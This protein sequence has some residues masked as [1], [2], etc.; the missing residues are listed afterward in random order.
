M[1]LWTFFSNDLN[2][3]HVLLPVMAEGLHVHI[4]CAGVGTCR[5][6]K[7]R[8]GGCTGSDPSMSPC[9]G[10]A[11]LTYLQTDGQVNPGTKSSADSSGGQPHILKQLR[12]GMCEGEARPL[13]RYHHA[14]P[15]TRQVH[16]A[17]LKHKHAHTVTLQSAW[18][19]S[20][21]V[22]ISLE[23]V[24]NA[25]VPPSLLLRCICGDTV[26]V[27]CSRAHQRQLIENSPC[28]QQLS[29]R[30]QSFSAELHD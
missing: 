4:H 12:E 25:A 27:S 21:Y 14:A 5:S 17:G 29:L 2:V 6:L 9:Q 22:S 15:H 7:Q 11:G 8:T 23:L 20:I 28:L 10:Q 16:S 19:I 24:I 13:L 1:F 26:S 18:I 3:V 30:S